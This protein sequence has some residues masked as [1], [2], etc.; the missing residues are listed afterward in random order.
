[1]IHG[2]RHLLCATALALAALLA[3]GGGCGGA[4]RTSSST[5]GNEAPARDPASFSAETVEPA[6]CPPDVAGCRAAT[7]RILYV[8]RN[9]PD[10]DG[11]AHFVIADP[12]GITFR[13]LT[14]IDVEASLRPQPLPGVGD[15]LSA[16]GPVQTG[17]FGQDQ[18]HAVVF[19]AGVPR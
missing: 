11:D 15:L 9:D 19:H 12:R 8:E 14:S 18:I 10:G 16:A 3:A 7:G 6:R 17:S 5:Q 2:R 13:G 4:E 1:L